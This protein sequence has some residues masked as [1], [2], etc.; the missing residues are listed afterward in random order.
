MVNF[1]NAGGG[2]PLC[3]L[4]R[5]EGLYTVQLGYAHGGI[6]MEP[7]RGVNCIKTGGGRTLCTLHRTEGLYG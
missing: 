7:H 4:N 3:T 6:K 2:D 1:I 5:A